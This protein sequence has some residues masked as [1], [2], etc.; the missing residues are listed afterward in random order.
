MITWIETYAKT[1]LFYIIL[2]V[3]GLIAFR[4]WEQEH[5]ARLLAEQQV[6]QS[7]AQ[8][9]TL[10]QQIT[11][12][13]AQATMKILQVKRDIQGAKTPAQ[14]V[15]AVPQLTDVPLNV[16]PI[17]GL[18]DGVVAVD[19]APLVQELGQCKIDSI[20][21]G[22]CQENYNNCQNIVTTREAEIKV[23]KKKPGFFHRMVGVAKAVGVGVGIGLFLG[24]KL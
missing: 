22:A 7:D 13:T 21:L 6:K 17:V 2:I 4:S 20:N 19:L 14:Q 11:T 1:H 18:P 9:K 15:A 23:L 16:R 3:V 12:T 10:Q 8:V 24:A 5:D